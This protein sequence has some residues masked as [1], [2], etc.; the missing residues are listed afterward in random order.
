MSRKKGSEIRSDRKSALV[1]TLAGW[2]MKLLS[3]TLRIEIH[4][5]C[6]IGSEERNIPP[7]IYVLWHNR[8]LWHDATT[9]GPSPSKRL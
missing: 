1:G 4:D 7:V 3:A 9:T 5:R 2:L 8:F 6:G